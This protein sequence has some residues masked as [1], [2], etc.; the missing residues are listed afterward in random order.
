MMKDKALEDL[1]LAQRPVFDDKDEF[2]AQLVRKLDAIEYLH[3]YEEANLLRY[4]YAMAATF[5]MGIIVGGIMLAIILSAPDDMPLIAFNATS[6]ILLVLEQY[7]RLIVSAA[8][9]LLLGF[10]IMHIINNVLDIAQMNGYI[11][12][13]IGE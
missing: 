7:S 10:G 13:Q 6:G 11:S 1:F 9:L 3:Q 8:L 2:M 5:A 12:H 4:K